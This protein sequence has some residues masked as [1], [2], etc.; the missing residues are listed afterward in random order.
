MGHPPVG[1]LGNNQMF[2]APFLT[3]ETCAFA[4]TEGP[5]PSP[6]LPADNDNEPVD[7]SNSNSN[8]KTPT[9]RWTPGGHLGH[10]RDPHPGLSSIIAT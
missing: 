6:V 5:S 8:E 3:T 4:F 1:Q 9:W 2:M 10:K 7:Y